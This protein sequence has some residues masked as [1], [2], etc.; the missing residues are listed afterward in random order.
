MLK[1]SSR[2]VF[3]LVVAALIAS[4]AAAQPVPAAAAT[5]G[6]LIGAVGCQICSQAFD[7]IDPAG[8]TETAIA[9]VGG[10]G[11]QAMVADPAL[12]LVYAS[13]GYGG[14]KGGA[15]QAAM[16]KLDTQTGAIT[17]TQNAPVLPLALALDPA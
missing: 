8:G 2:R 1:K 11:V 9:S 4:V 12:H 3:G 13:A 5:N 15:P 14:G 10:V 7:Q 6:T 16:I 17:V